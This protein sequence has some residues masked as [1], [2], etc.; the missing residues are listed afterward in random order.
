MNERINEWI[1]LINENLGGNHF[2]GFNFL[3]K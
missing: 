3:Y 1:E 2:D